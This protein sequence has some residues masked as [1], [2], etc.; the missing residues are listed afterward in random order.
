MRINNSIAVRYVIPIGILV[1]LTVLSYWNITGHQFLLW[2]DVYYVRD[3]VRYQSLSLENIIWMFADFNQIN[4]QPITS[5]SFAL[6]F[7]LSGNNA[8][9][10][11]IFN[12]VIHILNTLLVFIISGKIIPILNN[13]ITEDSGWRFSGTQITNAA[14]LSSLFFAIHPQHVE[15]VIWIIERKDV[16]CT[17]F[18]LAGIY[19]YIC[20]IESNDK[21]RWINATAVC[22]VLAIM[23]KS[24][25]VTFP[26]ALMLLDIFLFNRVTKGMPL[27][28]MIRQLLG[29]KVALLIASVGFALVTLF[30]QQ[31]ALQ[32]INSFSLSSRIINACLSIL[33][34]LYTFIAPFNLSPY[35]PPDE[36]ITIPL[37]ASLLPVV[38]VALL[39]YLAWKLLEKGVYFP[40]F[41]LSYF[42]ITLLPVVGL[43][44]VGH[45]AFAD[46][47][48]YIPS[49]SLHILLAFCIIFLIYK[50]KKYF[51]KGLLV[52]VSIS[53]LSVLVV[54]TRE[55][56]SDW[57]NDQTLW[58]RVVEVLP[59]KSAI[60]HLS[61]GDS[62]FRKKDYG[63]AL[64]QYK[65]G[66]GIEPSNIDALE[67]MAK[68]NMRL[69]HDTLTEHYMK[70]MIVRNPQ[71]SRAH[72]LLGDHYYRLNNVSIAEYYYMK[73]L[74]L[75]P[76]NT[77]A[78][79]K[80]AVMDANKN[81]ND[82]AIQKIGYILALEK[83]HTGA[84]QL[85]AQIHLKEG[86]IGESVKIA[87]RLIKTNP[88][89]KFAYDLLNYV[90]K[91]R[92]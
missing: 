12:I 76:L 7:W 14:F 4:W 67:H 24:M 58:S 21:R 75:T 9:A 51:L 29:N 87:K 2:D 65:I 33:H 41:A 26:A 43:V 44:K 89:D 84:L 5:L 53:Y 47:Y 52:I 11:K 78:I 71:S 70:Q 46:R 79:F 62:Y 15:S 57:Q 68:V 22:F 81:D 80:N 90:E 31:H 10:F 72:I 28:T 6:S 63:K 3:E 23:S 60:A 39:I 83:N 50:V 1:F 48:T 8:E 92:S 91:N 82:D 88:R 19:S 73:A 74:L 16:L 42:L 36:L 59:Y 35:Y 37:S 56:V 64:E 86:R 38:G 27:N 17:M 40:F 49:I 34:Y 85:L 69:H 32:E 20:Q 18:Y 55:Y 66:L 30:T 13:K 45:A 61:L 54:N 25:A 77:T